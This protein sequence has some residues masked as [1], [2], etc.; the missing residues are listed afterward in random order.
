MLHEFILA[1]RD[2][3]IERTRERVRQRVKAASSEA[4]L[5]YGIPLFLTQLV[6]ALTRAHATDPVGDTKVPTVI[7][8]SA[9]LHGT[10]LLANG[11]TIAQVV[12]GYGDVC[13]IVTELAV[14]SGAAIS[15]EE[16]HVFNRCLDDAIAG[17]VTT[18]GKQ[19][20][21]NVAYEGT[22]RLGVLAHELRNLLNTAVLS[23]DAIRR[24]AVGLGGSTAAMHARSLAGLR[25]LVEGS[26]A[27][28]QLAA[29]AARLER[30]TL[31][32]FFEDIELSAAME[33]E[34]R[35]LKLA[36]E[37]VEGDTA[38]DADRQLLTSAVSNLLQNAFKYS[39]AQG[40][41]LLRTRLTA[42]HVLIEVHDECGGLPAGEAEALF[43][44]FERGTSKKPGLGLGLVIAKKAVQANRGSL[45][46]RNVPGTGCVFTIEL[47]R[48]PPPPGV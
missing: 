19:S 11:F 29:G 15:A 34:S 48:Q 36:I 26:L 44:P 10:E 1:N 41:V 45:E 14:E 21:H 24:G 25:R 9:A 8:D 12:H 22:E 7:N 28:V 5:D 20:E 16:F 42:E 43:R 3:I 2:V 37:L 31:V 6:E 27:E 30:I 39:K 47:P 23:F 18:F 32:E 38:I 35:G 13:Q 40:S 4:R 33:A 17:A 46:V